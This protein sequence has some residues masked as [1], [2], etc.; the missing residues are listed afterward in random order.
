MQSIGKPE[1]SNGTYRLIQLFVLF[2]ALLFPTLKL[3][4]TI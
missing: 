1:A 3:W 2:D 4:I